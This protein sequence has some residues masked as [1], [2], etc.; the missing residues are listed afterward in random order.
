MYISRNGHIGSTHAYRMQQRQ[1]QKDEVVKL[2][3]KRKWLAKSDRKEPLPLPP[4]GSLPPT[5]IKCTKCSYSRSDFSS[6]SFSFPFSCI[7][8]ARRNPRGRG[9]KCQLTKGTGVEN[10]QEKNSPHIISHAWRH[11]HPIRIPKAIPIQTV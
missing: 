8:R 5:I 6:F 3:G 4:N 9:L 1:R 2:G 7:F 10:L 11:P